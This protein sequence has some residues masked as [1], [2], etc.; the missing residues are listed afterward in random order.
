MPCIQFQLCNSQ[1]SPY[2]GF[3]NYK[4]LGAWSSLLHPTV[5]YPAKESSYARCYPKYGCKSCSLL[6]PIQVTWNP[7]CQTQQLSNPPHA[8][9]PR[10]RQVPISSGVSSALSQRSGAK[11]WKRRHSSHFGLLIIQRDSTNSH[12][13]ADY[14]LKKQKQTPK[15][16]S[17][18]ESAIARVTHAWRAPNPTD[19]CTVNLS[20]CSSL[21][22]P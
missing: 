17:G 14:F 6:C 12:L 22:T 8:A 1:C 9:H 10:E 7:K 5:S 11:G 2:L 21:P 13:W 4:V 16:T 19:S 20:P 3:N 18:S 15:P